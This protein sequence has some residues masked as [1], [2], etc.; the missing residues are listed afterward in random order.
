[1]SPSASRS[2]RRSTTPSPTPNEHIDLWL[3]E[4]LTAGPA[5][6]DDGEFLDVFTTTPAQ[7]LAWV[8]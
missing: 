8:K 1:M 4:G 7:V 2:S 5:K 6:L 3:A